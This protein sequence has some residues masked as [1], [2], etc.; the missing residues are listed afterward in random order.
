MWNVKFSNTEPLE[1][2]W[3]TLYIIP[4][5]STWNDFGYRYRATLKLIYSGIYSE[6]PIYVI[7]LSTEPAHADLSNWIGSLDK[8][9]VFNVENNQSFPFFS[10]F[11]DVDCYEEIA[12]NISIT[13]TQA[14]LRQLCDITFLKS[15]GLV[16]AVLYDQFIYSSKFRLGVLRYSAAWKAFRR[17][18]LNARYTKKLDDAK[19]EF[20]YDCHLAGYSSKHSVEFRFKPHRFFDDRV[21]C[22]IGVNGVGKTR[23]LE[24]LISSLC[25]NA[26]SSADFPTPSL[27]AYS[28][29]YAVRTETSAALSKALPNFNYVLGYSSD[30]DTALPIGCNLGGPFQYRYFDIS[31]RTKERLGTEPLGLLFADIYRDQYSLDAA[32]SKYSI[33]KSSLSEVLNFNSILLPVVHQYDGAF[34]FE[35]RKREKWVEVK[36]LRGE[37]KSLE[38]LGAIDPT[39]DITISDEQ[40]RPSALSSGQRAFLRFALHFLSYAENGSLIL[41]DE[42]ET[43]LHPNMVSQF[44]VLLYKVLQATNSIAIIATHSVYVVREIPSHCAHIFSR[45]EDGAVATLQVYT[46]TLGANVNTLSRTVFDDNTISSYT[47]KI[48]D[49]VAT[50]GMSFAEVLTQYEDIFSVEMLVEIKAA[51]EM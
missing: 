37:L 28:N 34:S 22:I 43:H 47:S 2:E 13:D 16:S 12:R 21:H 44:M 26:N 41:I 36:N 38:V 45:G 8:D 29:A 20:S 4:F 19:V 46:K 51:M 14:I 24:S 32:I 25:T 23:Y 31:A 35:D 11:K 42:P 39:R 9:Q 30:F 7:P 3:G 50:S 18:F 40:G 5:D 48:I 17:G 10:L 33:L 15:Y 1:L 49:E 6:F 27:L